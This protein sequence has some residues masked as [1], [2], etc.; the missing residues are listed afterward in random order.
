MS[1]TSPVGKPPTANG[2]PRN[3]EDDEETLLPNCAV[4]SIPLVK[5]SR[6]S[7]LDAVRSQ[8]MSS[9]SDTAI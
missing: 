5:G 7:Q 3:R 6:L 4:Q 1:Q 2:A 9:A 8:W